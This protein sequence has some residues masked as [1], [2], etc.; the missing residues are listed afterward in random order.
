MSGSAKTPPRRLGLAVRL[1]AL[2]LTA[3]SLLFAVAFGY[4]YQQSRAL[5]L[6]NVENS[7]KSLTM[8]T[9]SKI[10]EVLHQLQTV[11]EAVAQGV[12]SHVIEQP[13]A[14]VMLAD[15]LRDTP[16]AFGGGLFLEDHARAGQARREAPYFVKRDG[17]VVYDPLGA[18]Y[19]YSFMDWYMLPKHLGR[20][21]W[22]E[23]YYDEAGGNILMAT[24]AV[25]VWQDL[26][27]EKLFRGVVTV[28]ISLE[29]LQRIVAKLHPG[30]SGYAFLV[31][32]TGRIVSH[33]N[34]ALIMRSSVFSRAEEADDPELRTVGRAMVR[35]QQG[36]A[37]LGGKAIGKPIW[38]YYAPL[39]G[40]EWSLGLVIPEDDLFADLTELHRDVVLIGAGGFTALLLLVVLIA[41]AVT[42]PIRLLAR[43]TI[44][45][46]KGNLDV[47]L[48]VVSRSDEVG[49]LS[50]SFHEMRRALK[51]YI[52]NL[53]ETTKAKERMES[54]LK[55]AKNIQMSFLPKRFPPFPDIGAFCLH[56]QLEP[57]Y[58][59]GGDLYDFFLLD[60]HRLF[61][62]VGDV[63]GK[64]V[65]AALFMAVT[66]T[67][68]KGI[69]EQ[70]PDPAVILAKVN[71]ELAEEND[72]MLFVTMFCAILDFR[73]GELAYSNAG[74][75]QPVLIGADGAA[76]FLALPPGTAMGPIPDL[77][78]E[79]RRILLSPGDTL[80]AYTDG[81]NE[82]QDEAEELFGNERL[83]GFLRRTRERAPDLLT[84]ALFAEVHAFAGKAP[85]ADD[86]TVLTLAWN[87]P[88]ADA[89]P[90]LR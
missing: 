3:T 78:Y 24:Y 80:V 1:A 58:E 52:A 50:R 33:P 48:P 7:A 70:D 23:P 29:S 88:D 65:P 21:Q 44:E 6:K 83:L 11:P 85:Q 60:E 53:T 26:D 32:R 72:A 22:S 45:I 47:D 36:F 35:G 79:T 87:G 13:Q 30:I 59:V 54:E 63:S 84:R 62:S 18:D 38:I 68:T 57:A 43:K 25:P 41:S 82:A 9:V 40:A 20:P 10:E 71:N 37:R 61:I 49:D 81:V 28:D 74:H 89:C 27:G 5:L 14:L 67:L 31:S 46:A 64:G 69:A 4:N 19:D 77:S 55:I 66:K 34:K 51:E 8:A 15:F 75:N 12:G 90:G 56:A 17:R 73:T 42:R 86:I 2:I 16:E 39:P 76:R